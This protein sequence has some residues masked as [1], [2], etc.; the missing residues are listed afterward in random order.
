[1]LYWEYKSVKPGTSV[2]EEGLLEALQPL[3][4][5]TINNQCKQTRSWPAEDHFCRGKCSELGHQHT[6][7]AGTFPPDELS[8]V[9]SSLRQQL[10]FPPVQELVQGGER[11]LGDGA[12]IRIAPHLQPHQSHA[13]VQG[14]VEL[15]AARRPAKTV[16]RKVGRFL[17]LWLKLRFMWS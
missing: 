3:S 17:K 15:R 12:F 16:N 9:V 6:P 4:C 2:W 1:M 5:L 7:H 8:V 13:D 11:V 10:D 14:P